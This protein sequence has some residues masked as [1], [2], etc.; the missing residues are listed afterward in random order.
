MIGI[1]DGDPII[2]LHVSDKTYNYLN[3]DSFII[4]FR[5]NVL[6]KI[7]NVDGKDVSLFSKYYNSTDGGVTIKFYF[8]F[9]NGFVVDNN[10]EY[11]NPN[12]KIYELFEHIKKS[13]YD[14]NSDALIGYLKNYLY[15]GVVSRYR[16]KKIEDKETS[17]HS[18]ELNVGKDA[19]V[20]PYVYEKLNGKGGKIGSLKTIN[21]GTN[22]VS[23]ETEYQRLIF[24]EAYYNVNTNKIEIYINKNYLNDNLKNLVL[25]LVLLEMAA[26]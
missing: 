1:I 16:E 18:E 4:G 20:I 13:L 22:K 6:S 17:V 12:G 14:K 21:F 11:E 8:A 24:D 26:I 5:E 10:N 15:T 9:E 2:Q 7:I 19:N 25:I 3:I 23:E